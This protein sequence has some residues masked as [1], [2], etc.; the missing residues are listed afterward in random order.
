M[1]KMVSDFY[2]NPLAIGNRSDIE[3]AAISVAISSLIF[4]RFRGDS[5]AI[6]RSALQFQSAAI[7]IAILRFGHLS[8]S[9][10]GQGISPKGKPGC[11]C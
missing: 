7:V 10:I 6:L 4:N 5:A 8:S 1:H 2:S 9:D 3:I 11:S